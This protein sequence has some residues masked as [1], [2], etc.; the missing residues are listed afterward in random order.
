MQTMLD[1]VAEWC[2]TWKMNLNMGKT[3]IMEF[4][5]KGSERNLAKFNIAG[6]HVEKCSHYKYLGI[7]FDEFLEFEK[8]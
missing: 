6:K 4:R 3:K 5:S 8:N 2:N 7:T 1:H